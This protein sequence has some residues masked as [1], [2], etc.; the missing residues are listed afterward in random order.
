MQVANR[1]TTILFQVIPE[2][3]AAVWHLLNLNF[4][5]LINRNYEPGNEDVVITAL[6]ASVNT[7]SCGALAAVVAVTVETLVLHS[8]DVE[9]LVLFH[10]S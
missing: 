7:A 3:N 8:T 5:S 2:N 4:T 10:N 6:A 1:E 9:V